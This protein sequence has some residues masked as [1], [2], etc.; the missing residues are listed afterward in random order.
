[1]N[2]RIGEELD[3]VITGVEDFGIFVQGT[4]I[5]AEGLLHTSALPTITTTMIASSIA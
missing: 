2:E 1:M 4:A 5:P 3:A